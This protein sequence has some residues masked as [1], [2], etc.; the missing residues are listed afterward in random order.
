L[1]LDAGRPDEA[2]GLETKARIVDAEQRALA[3]L[4]WGA[5]SDGIL[6]SEPLASEQGVCVAGL[7]HA[8]AGRWNDL[9]VAASRLAVVAAPERPPLPVSRGRLCLVILEAAHAQGTRRADAGER[10]RRADSLALTVPYVDMTWENLMVARLLDAAVDHRR[11][12]A[13]ATRYRYA[14]GYPSYLSS[15]LREG[16]EMAMRAGDPQ[17]AIEHLR[18]YLSLRD[19]P[20]PSRLADRAVAARLLRRLEAGRPE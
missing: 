5:R 1:A 12:A 7:S 19:D 11:A 17:R 2:R 9:Q 14:L 13:A 3:G 18:R 10:V 15:Y 6:A 8:E 20:E 4:F 16:A